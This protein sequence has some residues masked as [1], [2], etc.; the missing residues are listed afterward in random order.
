MKLKSIFFVILTGAIDEVRDFYVK[1]FDFK[2]VFDADWYVHL[3]G[4]RDGGG[5]P[6]ELAFMRPDSESLPP[7]LRYAFDG[8]GLFITIEAEDVDTLY[9]RLRND[10]HDIVLELCDEAWGQRHFILRD[11]S[12]SLLDVV[13]PIP[14]SAQYQAAYLEGGH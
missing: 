13:K 2:V 14:P 12:G 6:L 4:Q 11:P 8:K 1:Y 3:H 5:A 7:S 10:N 9:Q